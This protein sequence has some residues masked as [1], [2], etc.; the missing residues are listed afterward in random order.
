MNSPGRHGAAYGMGAYLLWGIF[1]LYFRLLERSGAVEVVLHR[2]LWSL[3]VCAV[4]LTA[5]RQW[6]VLRA[7][8]ASARTVGVLGTAAVLLAVNWGTYIYGVNSGHV[9]EASLGYFINPLVTVLLGVVVLKERLRPAQWVAVGLGTVAVVVLTVD[10]GR[11]PV[12][13]LTLAV[14]FGMYGLLKNRVGATVG[15]LASLSTE[16]LLL[17]PLAA[18][19]IVVLELRGQGH[20]A[21][22]APWQ[23]LLLMTTGIVTV[24]PLLFFAA[25]A[26]RIPLSTMG[27]LQYITPVL[28]LLCGV[29]VFGERMPL[30]R[31]LGFGIVWAALAVMTVDS[32]RT[33]RIRSRAAPA[34]EPVPA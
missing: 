24:V 34:A 28:Q 10:Y 27:L 3:L 30:S 8:L 1:P 26:R 22:D 4:V 9:V 21:D 15:A 13:A 29:L 17:A 32:L 20:F 33:A 19:G 16:T 23:A 14:T 31:W 6:S 18:V 11:P 12:I 5:V 25:A 2:I 7:T